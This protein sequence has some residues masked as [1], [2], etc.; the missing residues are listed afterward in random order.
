MVSQPVTV[1]LALPAAT[2]S[3][4]VA[5]FADHKRLSVRQRRRWL[6][7]LLNWEQKNSYA[8]Y[9]EDGNHTLQV[10]EEGS[11]LWNLVKRLLLRTARPFDAVVYDN[12]IPKPMLKLHRP[13]RF[14]FHRLEVS[15]ADGTPI[16]AIERRWSWLR[17]I[18]A[19]TDAR[20]IAKLPA[21]AP[22]I[23]YSAPFHFSRLLRFL[24]QKQDTSTKVQV[25]LVPES[26]HLQAGKL[27]YLST[28]LFF[29]R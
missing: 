27:Y 20:E 18:Y 6:E 10:K 22:V 24:G 9:D 28:H 16:G 21:D 8:V 3:D 23:R 25:S 17:R 1:P 26:F 13:F 29:R 7:L 12:P 11:G 4:A 5:E 2:V 14:F 15:A 19:I